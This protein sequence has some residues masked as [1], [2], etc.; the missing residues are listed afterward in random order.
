LEHTTNWKNTT[1]PIRGTLLPVFYI[2]YFRKDIPQGSISSNDEKMKLAKMGPGY[3]VW[4]TTVSGAIENSEE[5]NVLI[6]AYSAVAD[7]SLNFYQKHFYGL[8][9]QTTSIPISGTPFGTITM[10]QSDSYPVEVEAIKKIFFP[11]QQVLLQAPVTAPS[12]TLL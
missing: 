5:I 1:D 12:V 9:N 11:V 6:D 7:L 3:G 8:Y 10:V 2:V 4:V